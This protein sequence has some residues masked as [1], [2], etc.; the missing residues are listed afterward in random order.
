[1]L[2]WKKKTCNSDIVLYFFFLRVFDTVP[3]VYFCI[4]LKYCG[5]EEAPTVA[6]FFLIWQNR[7]HC[8]LPPKPKSSRRTVVFSRRG[9]V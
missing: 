4:S 8:C 2:E 6:C 3:L 9:S 7:I 1:M 5:I